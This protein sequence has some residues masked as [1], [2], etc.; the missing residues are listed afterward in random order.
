[1]TCVASLSVNENGD[2]MTTFTRS[3]RSQTPQT[4]NESAHAEARSSGERV[5]PK[6]RAHVEGGIATAFVLV[7][8][9]TLLICTGLAIDGARFIGARRN[10]SLAAGAAAR[11]GSQW[12]DEPSLN[13]GVLELDEPK[14]VAE[15]ERVLILQKYQPQPGDVKY[16]PGGILRVK[17]RKEVPTVLLWVIGIPSKT[18][19][20]SATSQIIDEQK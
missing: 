18:V 1:V 6:G 7:L 10:A 2:P 4:R 8:S 11:S 17:V 14:A 19:T 9:V 16:L 15:V 5:S 12:L 3:P 13:K 20:A